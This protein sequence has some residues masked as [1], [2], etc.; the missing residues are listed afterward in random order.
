MRRDIREAIAAEDKGELDRAEAL[1][2]K[3]HRTYPGTF[4]VDES[5]V[6]FSRSEATQAGHCPANCSSTRGTF[7]R[8]GP[9]EP[10]CGAASG[11]PESI[12]NQ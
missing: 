3:L 7:I 5:L 12:R 4:V 9:R 6:Y 8:R 10:R 11:S 1:S 2:M